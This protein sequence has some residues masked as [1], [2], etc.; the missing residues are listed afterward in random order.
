MSNRKAVS[1]IFNAIQ[2]IKAKL[3]QMLTHVLYH[4]PDSDGSCCVDE[5]IY[6]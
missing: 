1:T 3:R 6:K 5:R 4:D 2:Y